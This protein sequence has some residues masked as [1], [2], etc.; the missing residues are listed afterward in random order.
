[1]SASGLDLIRMDTIAQRNIV[2]SM[3]RLTL[4]NSISTDVVENTVGLSHGG[5]VGND[6]YW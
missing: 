2:Q 3:D 6:V 5:C 1:M 4:L